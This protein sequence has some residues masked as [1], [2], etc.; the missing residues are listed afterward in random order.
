ML[1]RGDDEKDAYS[2]FGDKPPVKAADLVVWGRLG[3]VADKK[4]RRNQAR[5]DTS[6]SFWATPMIT[7]VTATAFTILR[8]KG[9]LL[10]VMSVGSIG[11]DAL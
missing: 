10:P 6:A 2:Y 3:I 1:P 5:R 4:S 7:V 8:P 11:T 9:S